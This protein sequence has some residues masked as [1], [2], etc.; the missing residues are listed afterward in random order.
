MLVDPEAYTPLFRLLHLGLGYLFS[1]GKAWA[2]NF[3]IVGLRVEGLGCYTLS[4]K[5]QTLNLSPKP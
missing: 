4:P 2:L 1:G 3:V 5:P